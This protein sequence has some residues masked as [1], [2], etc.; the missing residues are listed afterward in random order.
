MIGKSKNKRADRIGVIA[1]KKA[2]IADGASFTCSI[3][4]LKFV[5][6][7]KK[8]VLITVRTMTSFL[9]DLSID[10]D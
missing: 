9:F 3:I 5:I 1:T 4:R 10:V 2:K 8:Y 7:Y 6:K